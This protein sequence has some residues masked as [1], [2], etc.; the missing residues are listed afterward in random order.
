MANQLKPAQEVENAQQA[1]DARDAEER[2]ELLEGTHQYERIV[3]HRRDGR[4]KYEFKIR[5]M[6]FG[7]EEDTWE[8]ESNIVD[9]HWIQVYFQNLG[10]SN[11]IQGVSSA[12]QVRGRGRGAS[13]R[14]SQRPRQVATRPGTSGAD[15]SRV[16]GN[17]VV[18]FTTSKGRVGRPPTK[19]S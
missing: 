11:E 17:P 3:G 4:G 2:G 13:R 8:P 15:S 7:P 18:A 10:A 16:T 6:G 12:V 5:W 19:F 9:K 1:I 14:G